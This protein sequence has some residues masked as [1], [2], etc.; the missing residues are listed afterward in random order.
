MEL[1][2]AYVAHFKNIEDQ[3][4][5]LSSRC[6][7]QYDRKA[8]TLSVKPR[9]GY[10]QYL[11]G[12]GISN[13]TGI[14]GKNGSGKS[15]LLEFLV[16]YLVGTAGSWQTEAILIFLKDENELLYKTNIP[17]LKFDLP[18]YLVPKKH[19]PDPV[20]GLQTAMGS[21][22]YYSYLYDGE[23]RRFQN[24]AHRWVLDLSTNG[25][26]ERWQQM[27]SQ[28]ED[29]DAQKV[30]SYRA[31]EMRN[32]VRF[33]MKFRTDLFGINLPTVIEISTSLAYLLELLKKTLRTEEYAPQDV[34]NDIDFIDDHL[35]NIPDNSYERRV[36]FFGLL[37]DQAARFTRGIYTDFIR[38][39]VEYIRKN[40]QIS[41]EILFGIPR[42][43]NYYGQVEK[44]LQCFEELKSF[45]YEN[46]FFRVPIAHGGK[47]INLINA[48]DFLDFQI[49]NPLQFDLYHEGAD[50]PGGLSA[51][52]KSFLSL[53]SR[54]YIAHENMG[55]GQPFVFLDEADVG[56]HPQW[57]KQLFRYLCAYLPIILHAD[58]RKPIQI[59]ITAHSPFIA[60]DLPLENILFLSKDE[61]GKCQVNAGLQHERTFAANIHT[62]FS[63]AFFLED[64]LIGEFAQE[65]IETLITAI[66]CFPEDG[67]IPWLK[68]DESERRS[69]IKTLIEKIG[70]PIIR[71]KLYELFDSHMPETLEEKKKRLLE[72]LEET[73][74]KLMDN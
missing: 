27:R 57:Q 64:G 15:N 19:E 32:L 44:T 45:R 24:E 1:L 11:F 68:G 67:D 51:G 53:L 43:N 47:V 37:Y 9:G 8:S 74:K 26:V 38:G 39:I 31:S 62:L 70:E 17:E 20:Y 56:F 3:E 41:D 71:M 55:S 48:I 34:Y 73:N 65:T 63:D 54:F 58:Y 60:S 16:E 13:V 61:S 50:T 22:Y 49:P 35:S 6:N 33:L 21:C 23:L 46:G 52:E 59:F 14:I 30:L 10:I 18:D 25:I 7:I 72:E 28:F 4:F 40:Q 5:N 2:Y 29:T 42:K 69:I 36:L 66:K 12:S